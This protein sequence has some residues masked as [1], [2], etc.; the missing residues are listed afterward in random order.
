MVVCDLWVLMVLTLWK[1]EWSTVAMDYGVHCLMM[2]L[3]AGMERWCVG[4]WDITNQVSHCEHTQQLL[5]NASF[6]FILSHTGVQIFHSSY[7]GQGTGPIVFANLGCDGTESILD[8]CTFGSSS[9]ND[10][11]S[12][13]IG[14]HCYERRKL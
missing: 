8:D 1:E 3:T 10:Y 11:H 14:L 13:D 7:Y 12:E 4:D 6:W 2:A 5:Q 9:F